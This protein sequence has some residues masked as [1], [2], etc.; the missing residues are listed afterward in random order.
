MTYIDGFTVP[1]QVQLH[2]YVRQRPISLHI[3]APCP[4]IVSSH[5][6]EH[7]IFVGPA[8]NNSNYILCQSREKVTYQISRI[9]SFDF[10][11]ILTVGNQAV[12]C[13]C[14][15]TD[16]T[17]YPTVECRLV[18]IEATDTWCAELLAVRLD[19]SL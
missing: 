15:L 16:S 12:A 2:Y 13:K 9:N 10:I 7:I 3:S 5:K 14:E 8:V 19:L 6:A 4:R 11:F 17:A 18:V 1:V